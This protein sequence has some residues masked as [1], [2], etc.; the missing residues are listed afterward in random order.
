MF[1]Y[2]SILGIIIFILQYEKAMALL[3]EVSRAFASAANRCDGRL[4][5][6][7]PVPHGVIGS[8]HFLNSCDMLLGNRIFFQNAPKR[9][10]SEL[11]NVL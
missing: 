5:R 3:T 2:K 1:C 11:K 9:M 6:R 10:K 8:A 4:R 7:N